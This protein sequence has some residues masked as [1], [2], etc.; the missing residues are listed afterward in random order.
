MQKPFEK[1]MAI[2]ETMNLQIIQVLPLLLKVNCFIN[3]ESDFDGKIIW[4]WSAEKFVNDDYQPI[5][6]N[7]NFPRR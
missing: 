4:D 7:P 5:P 2:A 3:A 1:S 6:K